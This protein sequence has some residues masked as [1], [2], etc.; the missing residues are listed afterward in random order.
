MN[1][2]SH[3]DFCD[4]M[5]RVIL[6]LDM[7][8]FYASIE[9]RDD[10]SLR[11]QPVIVGAAPGQRGVVCAASYEAR[12]FGIRAA[13]PSSTAKRMCPGGIFVS[14]RMSHYREE[15]RQIMKI[16]TETGAIVEPTSIDEAYLDV[17][18]V[19]QAADHDTSLQKSCDIGKR[20]KHRILAERGLTATVGVGSN[21]LLAKIAS[22]F[23]KP[24]GFTLILESEKV[25]FLRPLCVGKIYGVGPV[26]KQ[27]LNRAHLHTIGDLQ[28]HPGDLQSLVGSFGTRLKR[29]S[30]GEDCRPLDLSDDI[31]S[32]SVEDTFQK[33]T[34]APHAIHSCLWDQAVKIS[35]KLRIRNLSARRVGVTVRYSDF[36][37]ASR[38]STFETAINEEKDI[39]YRACRLLI[40]NKLLCCPLRM[41]GLKVGQLCET[42]VGQLQLF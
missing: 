21:K 5:F 19:C 1:S 11:G 28:D 27:A 18:C 25:K 41:I 10:P 8:A 17:S 15:S 36:T 26:A 20:L 3:G 2:E 34:T 6:H 12:K 14:P 13:L 42:N 37:T 38:Q 24:N 9:Q 33:D 4:G 16:L 35:G 23:Q 29:F 30:F 31:Q 22:D 32:A 39:Y 7:D 40:Q